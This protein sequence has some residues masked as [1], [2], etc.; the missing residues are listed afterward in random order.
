M[1]RDNVAKI[2]PVEL[3]PTEH[4][5][6]LDAGVVDDV[7]QVLSHGVGRALVPIL[8]LRCLLRG[9]DVDEAPPKI[10]ETIGARDV[11][12]QRRGVELRQ[13]EHP[14]DAA[15][16]AIADR[17][18]DEA[19]LAAKGNGRLGALASQRMK[20]RPNAS[21]EDHPNGFVRHGDDIL[22]WHRRYVSTP[23]YGKI[24]SG[25]MDSLKELLSNRP[26]VIART[27]Q[28]QLVPGYL[29]KGQLLPRGILKMSDVNGEPLPV[30]LQKLKGVFFV[31]DFTGDGDYLEEK[32]LNVDPNRLGLRVR[33][34]FDDNESLEG[35]TENTLE[36][37]TSP[38]FFFWPGDAKS[39]NR[40]IFVVKTALLGFVVLGVRHR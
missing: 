32:S 4:E 34:R 10:I 16:Q 5:R 20:A 7:T 35:V 27:K 11:I 36:L 8:C 13:H 14:P 39:N 28:G 17:N 23:N 21:P 24:K 19:V 6:A 30:D 3:I 38:G 37:L 25:H 12:V 33:I 2:H 40:L 15:V 18:V 31:H 29:D 22:P 1:L 9:K 26:K